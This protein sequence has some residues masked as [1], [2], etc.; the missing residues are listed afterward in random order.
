MGKNKKIKKDE[1]IHVEIRTMGAY[2][3][4]P[5]SMKTRIKCPVCGEA[6]WCRNVLSRKERKEL[7]CIKCGEVFKFETLKDGKVR[8]EWAFK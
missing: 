1:V 4:C 2:E 5:V 3:A 6:L 8:L 7:F